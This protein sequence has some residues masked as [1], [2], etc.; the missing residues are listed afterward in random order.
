MNLA[1]RSPLT[2]FVGDI[3]SRQDSLVYEVRRCEVLHTGHVL[4]GTD[5]CYCRS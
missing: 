2:L 5:L 1:G 3:N 4:S